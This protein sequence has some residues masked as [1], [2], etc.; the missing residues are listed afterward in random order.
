MGRPPGL[1][2]RGCP[3]ILVGRGTGGVRARAFGPN[4]SDDPGLAIFETAEGEL[5]G[6]DVAPLT[7]PPLQGAKLTVLEAVRVPRSQPFEEGLCGDIG[8][9]LQPTQHLGPHALEGV[10]SR[11]P[12]L[13][14]PASS[15]DSGACDDDRGQRTR[16]DAAA[17]AESAPPRRRLAGLSYS[18][19][20]RRPFP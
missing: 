10:L 12:V 16:D 8:L 5:S 18:G 4:W 20:A 14:G 17:Q 6:H 19:R 3:C 13:S 9:L 7:H 1:V 15:T 2:G 11:T